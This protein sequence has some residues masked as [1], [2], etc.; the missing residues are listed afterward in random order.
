VT[1]LDQLVHALSTG[2]RRWPGFV[3][4]GREWRNRRD[5]VFLLVSDGLVGRPWQDSN[6]RHLPP[7]GSALSPELQGHVALAT[8]AA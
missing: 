5:R 7:E 4:W 1:S 2:S 8:E 6:L 3:G